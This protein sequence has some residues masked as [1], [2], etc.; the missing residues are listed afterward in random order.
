MC[1]R[2]RVRGGTHLSKVL[3]GH[4]RLEDLAAAHHV[5]LAPLHK[6][7]PATVLAAVEDHLPLDARERGELVHELLDEGVRRLPEDRHA[8]EHR[9]V[10]AQP[11]L[12][13]EMRWQSARHRLEA[14]A[15]CHRTLELDE[16][17]YLR[18]ELLGNTCMHGGRRDAA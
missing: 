17:A 12:E 16:R 15:A 5:R 9:P 13:D 2:G 14:N 8:L 10:Q 11:D 18:L 7:H 3:A 4:E 1:T 6:E